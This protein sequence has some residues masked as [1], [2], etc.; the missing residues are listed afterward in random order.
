MLDELNRTTASGYSVAFSMIGELFLRE[1]GQD[2]LDRLHAA[3]R[4]LGIGVIPR[5]DPDASLVQRFYDRTLV[6]ATPFFVPLYE[7]CIV[8]GGWV[9]GKFEF[10]PISGPTTDHV[11]A[12]YRAA[13]FDYGSLEVPQGLSTILH[14]DYLGCECA[15]MAYLLSKPILRGT[16]TSGTE[17]EDDK[18]V[19]LARDFAE[20]HLS[21][22]VDEAAR[23]LEM[24]ERDLYF[25]TCRLLGQLLE[26]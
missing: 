19:D 14:P 21:R 20:M 15:F 2:L 9:D 10:G 25:Q 4:S 22:W 18:G 17:G 8:R 6:S 5:I 23:V 13:G 12:C 7:N 24:S 26:I 16:G 1:P 3:S 11:A